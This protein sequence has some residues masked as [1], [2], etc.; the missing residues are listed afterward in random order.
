[1]GTGS[2]AEAI[3]RVPVSTTTRATH[4]GSGC[5]ICAAEATLD[6]LSEVQLATFRE[7]AVAEPAR[8]L[9]GPTE[10]TNDARL[11][12]PS[13]AICTGFTSEQYKDA[14]KE[15]YTWLAGFAELQNLSWLDLPTSHWPM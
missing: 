5:L 13:T 3:V 14:V 7:R 12:V 2:T 4:V 15:G 10:L 9:R 6:G 11:D 1:M 8:A